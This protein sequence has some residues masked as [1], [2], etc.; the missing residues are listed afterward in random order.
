MK[1]W[2]I[3]TVGFLIGKREGKCKNDPAWDLARQYERE[4]RPGRNFKLWL[5]ARVNPRFDVG[6][7]HVCKVEQPIEFCPVCCHWFCAPCDKRTFARGME[8]AKELVG[9]PKPGCCGPR[10]ETHDIRQ[11]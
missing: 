3:K 4:G 9:K 11:A 2:M 5:G 1:H 8:A 6:V 10:L 7:C